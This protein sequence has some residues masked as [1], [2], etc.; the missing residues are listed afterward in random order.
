MNFS[1][2]LYKIVLAIGGRGYRAQFCGVTEPLQCVAARERWRVG[3]VDRGW[4][5]LCS[6]E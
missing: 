6:M 3:A 4:D 2:K 5:F 1:A